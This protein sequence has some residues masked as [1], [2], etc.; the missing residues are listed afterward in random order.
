MKMRNALLTIYGI[1]FFLCW[2]VIGF[3]KEK[4]S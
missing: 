3:I 1:M 2:S 4:M